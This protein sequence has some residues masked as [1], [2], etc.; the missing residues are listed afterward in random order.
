MASSDPTESSTAGHGHGD[1]CAEGDECGH[2][3]HGHHGQDELQH[4]HTDESQEK[5]ENKRLDPHDYT[6]TSIVLESDPSLIS[7]FSLSL[8][9]SGD[10]QSDR[11]NTYPPRGLVNVELLEKWLQSMLWGDTYLSKDQTLVP[12]RTDADYINTDTRGETGNSND[13]LS[14]SEQD[15]ARVDLPVKLPDALTSGEEKLQIQQKIFRIKGILHTNDEEKGSLFLQGVES[16]YDLYP[17]IQSETV[18]QPDA[19]SG[20]GDE[21]DDPDSQD[22]SAAVK[23]MNHKTQGTRVQNVKNKSQDDNNLKALGLPACSRVVVIGRHL[24]VEKL[25]EGFA[26]CFQE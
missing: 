4:E 26:Q 23:P 3:H 25:R 10:K 8:S 20:S 17:A 6:I 5:S 7:N 14:P 1:T 15:S 13:D 22:E 16:L 9:G 2:E 12:P 24:H 11:S 19:D 18:F 21:S